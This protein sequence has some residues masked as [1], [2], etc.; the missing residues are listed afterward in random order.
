MKY[1][2]SNDGQTAFCIFNPEEI[3]DI[4]EVS[5]IQTKDNE[6]DDTEYGKG[7]ANFTV[8]QGCAG[9]F[10]LGFLLG[11]NPD[12]TYR[13]R[14]DDCDFKFKLNKKFQTKK[15]KIVKIDIKTQS[16]SYSRRENEYYLPEGFDYIEVG[17]FYH[18][19]RKEVVKGKDIIVWASRSFPKSSWNKF[20]NNNYLGEGLDDSVFENWRVDIWGWSLLKDLIEDS[21][22]NTYVTK[23]DKSGKT[24]NISIPREKL[25]PIKQLIDKKKKMFPNQ[26]MP[27]LEEMHV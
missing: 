23:K 6:W 11:A 21:P 5:R 3:K 10:F 24:L 13:S 15:I 25:R 17:G 1:K 14:G 9:E 20:E 16:H 26:I 7:L 22:Q 4:I 2:I 12:K 27:T 8:L 19:T 18:F